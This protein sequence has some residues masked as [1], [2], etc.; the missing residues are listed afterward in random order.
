MKNK[1]LIISSI[2]L[3]GIS[4]VL[5]VTAWSL[6]WKQSAKDVIIAELEKQIKDDQATIDQL[7]S[8][9][10][11][12]RQSIKSLEN[13]LPANIAAANLD[14]QYFM[15]DP[16]TYNPT[17]DAINISEKQAAE[18]AQKGFEESKLRIAGEGADD[19]DS[20]VITMTDKAPDNYF[21]KKMNERYQSYPHARHCYAITR[22][23]E[24]KCGITIYVDATTGLIIGG[25]SF[26]D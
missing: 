19:I 11:S 16:E 25:Y 26:G 17:S 23:N 6:Y 10:E 8:Q 5:A 15:T 21:T 3:I 24:L 4:I 12:I 13:Q 7:E 14:P 20:Q 9:L 22:T 18:I 1:L 2:I